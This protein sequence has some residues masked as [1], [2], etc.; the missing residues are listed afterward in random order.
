MLNSAPYEEMLPDELAEAIGE[1]AV[2][3][4]V[5]K[6]GQKVRELLATVNA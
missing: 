4:M 2:A 6:I 5:D 1:K 3:L